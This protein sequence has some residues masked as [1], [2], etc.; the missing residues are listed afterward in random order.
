M[1]NKQLNLQHLMID[2][3]ENFANKENLEHLS[4]CEMIYIENLTD[5]Q[6]NFLERYSNIYNRM[7][8]HL[9][10][11]DQYIDFYERVEKIKD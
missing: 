1:K 2:I 5:K 8:N 7:L 4:A 10:H 6:E 11:N 3:L 9:D